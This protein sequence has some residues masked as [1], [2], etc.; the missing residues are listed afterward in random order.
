MR[1]EGLDLSRS[2]STSARASRLAGSF[3][4][5]DRAGLHHAV[6]LL[7]AAGGRHHRSRAG[8]KKRCGGLRGGPTSRASF[9]PLWM[10]PGWAPQAVSTYFLRRVEQHSGG[11]TRYKHYLKWLVIA[12][13]HQQILLAQ[14]A[15]QG[16]WID[17]RALPGLVDAGRPT[18]FR[19][20][21]CWPMPSLIP[22]P[23]TN[24]FG[25]AGERRALSRRNLAGEFPKEFS[26]E[27]CTGSFRRKRY[28]QRAKIET[29]SRWS[30]ANS[31]PR[32]PGPQL[33]F[34]DPPSP[35]ARP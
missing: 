29:T 1:Y 31:P 33:G 28:G 23:T 18:R 32:A 19:C 22:K 21:W 14:R 7:A 25:S 15:R 4:T 3:A 24:I 10:A 35:V 11:K 20:A 5:A 8:R 12:D 27:R 30:S 13:V 17:T 26:V 16:P 6:S 34:A 9:G 2:R